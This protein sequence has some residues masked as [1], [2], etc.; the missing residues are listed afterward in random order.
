M[1]ASPDLP[2]EGFVALEGVGL[3]LLSSMD[4]LK[5]LSV[6][7]RNR[8]IWG[9]YKRKHTLM[10]SDLE[11]EWS[12]TLSGSPSAESEPESTMAG[13]LLRARALPLL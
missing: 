2:L 13:D 3:E 1:T 9:I 4:I 7:A 5:I 10:D 11:S 12:A 8:D 6:S